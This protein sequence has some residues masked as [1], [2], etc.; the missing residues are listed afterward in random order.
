MASV[1]KV[2]EVL[3]RMKEGEPCK[4]KDWDTRVVPQ[5]VRRILKKHELEN[6]W[7]KK[8]FMNHD[9]ALADRFFEAGLE[10][11]EVI[12]IH[13]TDLETVV[14]FSRNEI[15]RNLK[16][17]K[18]ELFLG[19]GAD[20]VVLRA[21]RVEDKTKP[22][23]CAP[24]AIQIDEEIYLPLTEGIVSSRSVDILQGP[25]IEY[26]LRESGVYRNAF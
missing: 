23:Y 21:R 19:T 24:L 2:L 22:L 10:L 12:G 9:L 20:R 7:D 11:A 4:T 6:K 5:T 14:H 25:S 15:L 8:S 17:S 1:K 16:D 13:C 26:H 3:Y 18:E